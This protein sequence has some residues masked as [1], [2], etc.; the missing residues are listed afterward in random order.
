M[1]VIINN[2]SVIFRDHRRSEEAKSV[3]HQLEGSGFLF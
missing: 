1:M 2:R 3:R